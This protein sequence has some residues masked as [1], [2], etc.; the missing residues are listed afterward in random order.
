MRDYGLAAAILAL[1][2]ALVKFD[3]T[4]G[5]PQERAAIKAKMAAAKP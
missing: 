1:M 3:T 5:G 4:M 2:A